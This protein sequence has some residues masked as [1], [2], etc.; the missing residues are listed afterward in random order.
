MLPFLYHNDNRKDGGIMT[1]RE[2]S[3]FVI[4]IVLLFI[5]INLINLL[6]K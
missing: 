6:Y 5:I 1:K 4:I 3:Q 2:I